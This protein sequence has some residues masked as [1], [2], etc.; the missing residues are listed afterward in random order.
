MNGKHRYFD[1]ERRKKCKKQ[2]VLHLQWI[3]DLT[4]YEDIKRLPPVKVEDYNTDK[5]Q[6]TSDERI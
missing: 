2:P 3:I 1:R 4:E 6:Q 5:H